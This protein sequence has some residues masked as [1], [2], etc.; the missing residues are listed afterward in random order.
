MP[1]PNISPK[2]PCVPR[3]IGDLSREHFTCDKAWTVVQDHVQK[4]RSK[5][6]TL[7]QKVRRLNKKI[8][9]LNSLL[10]HLKESGLL[11]NEGCNAL[12]V[13]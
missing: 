9:D 8:E 7:N 5:S 6:K 10:T 1:E 12:E 4:C 13:S 11:S 2:R 3:Y